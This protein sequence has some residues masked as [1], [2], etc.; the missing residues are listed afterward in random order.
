MEGIIIE[1][2]FE[3]HP[4]A[5]YGS[6][7]G[8]TGLETAIVLIGFVVVSSVFAFAALSAGLFSSDQSDAVV[9]AGLEETRGTLEPRGAVIA[10]ATVT[11]TQGQEGTG[12]GVAKDFTLANQPVIPGSET[13]YLDDVVQSRDTYAAT[14]K[15]GVVSFNT[16]P[17]NGAEVDVT[18]TH[19]TISS[20]SVDLANAAGGEPVSMASGDLVVTYM[21]T[22]NFSGE[23][24][25]VTVT[26]LGNAD[27]DDLLEVGDM[28][29]VS[30]DL[31]SYSLTTQDSFTIQVKPGQGAVV[32]VARSI[33]NKIQ[34]AMVLN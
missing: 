29:N 32:I 5:G 9:L 10:R 31:S 33:P 7:R 6:Q 20:V 19:Y 30:V 14:Y 16:P 11:T 12:D 17:A 8:I 22:G 15:T 4:F 28:F 3:T 26:K 25:G 2:R 27:A 23:A 13:V 18:Y 24:P 21:D 34:G 1:R